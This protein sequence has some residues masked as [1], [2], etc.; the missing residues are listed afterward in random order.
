MANWRFSGPAGTLSE[1]LGFRE[2]WR[3][4]DDEDALQVMAMRLVGQAGC[5]D[6]LGAWNCFSLA[7]SNIVLA[8]GTS[9]FPYLRG[10]MYLGPTHPLVMFG[11][12]ERK[13]PDKFNPVDALYVELYKEDELW[14][15]PRH[16]LYFADY[17]WTLPLGVESMLRSYSQADTHWTEGISRLDLAISKADRTLR[18]VVMRERDVALM[19]SCCLKSTVN[20]ARF[21]MQRDRATREPVH[22]AEVEQIRDRLVE[23]VEDDLRNAENGY[24]LAKRDYRFGYGFAYGKAFDAQMIS[25]KIEFTKNVLLPDIEQFF[26]ILASHAFARTYGEGGKVL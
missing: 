2:T 5:H 17:R 26:Y 24:E 13:L 18:T 8:V 19:V 1:E 6:L 4:E 7:W 20:L 9:G 16:P 3:S 12:Q 23:I 21:Q 15:A 14:K 10:P 22:N 11:E 25:D